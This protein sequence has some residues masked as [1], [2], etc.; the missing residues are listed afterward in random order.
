[1]TWCGPKYIKPNN[2]LSESDSSLQSQ[3]NPRRPYLTHASFVFPNRT[4]SRVGKAV[5]YATKALLKEARQQEPRR[6]RP[7]DNPRLLTLSSMLVAQPSSSH[8]SQA[9]PSEIPSDS[10]MRQSHPTSETRSVPSHH[11]S[12]PATC[13]NC[14]AS[15]DLYLEWSGQYLQ[16]GNAK[17][18]DLSVGLG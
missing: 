17:P 3:L 1:M 16:V 15:L 4:E 13:D 18:L 9:L 2:V 14:K 8:P 5:L 12:P 11:A 10:L 6:A 7:G